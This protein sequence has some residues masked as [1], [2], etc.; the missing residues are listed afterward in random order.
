MK[1]EVDM[2]TSE[3]DN[4]VTTTPGRSSAAVMI[5]DR[6]PRVESDPGSAQRLPWQEFDLAV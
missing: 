3:R 2:A 6:K 1:E 4:R 5:F